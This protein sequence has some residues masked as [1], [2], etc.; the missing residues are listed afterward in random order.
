MHIFFRLPDQIS[1]E[2]IAS[3]DGSTIVPMSLS[4]SIT[5]YS[6][7]H[8][9]AQ[10]NPICFDNQ[11]HISRFD[12]DPLPE[13]LPDRKLFTC[14]SVKDFYVQVWDIQTG[15]L[16]GKFLTSQMDRIALLPILIEHFPNDRL[17]ALWCR[18]ADRICL[19]NISTGHLHA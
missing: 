19:F 9:T 15:H 3:P 13:Y 8:D 2:H 10:F 16:L 5:C 11:V 17:I 12:K 4:H 18:F 6:W 1:L 7:N 14:W